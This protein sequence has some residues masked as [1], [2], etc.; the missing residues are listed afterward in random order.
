MSNEV[1]PP[2]ELKQHIIEQYDQNVTQF[3][4]V[5]NVSRQTVY[6]WIYADAHWW[7]GDVWIRQRRGEL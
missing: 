1:D 5:M 4:K 2:I 3:A 6:N 7:K